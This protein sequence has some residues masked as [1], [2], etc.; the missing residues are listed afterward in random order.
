M[1]PIGSIPPIRHPDPVEPLRQ[2]APAGAAAFSSALAGALEGV[3]ALQKNAESEITRFLSGEAV[4]I[5]QVALAHQ[6]AQLSFELFL[7]VR[8]KFVQ[9]YQEIMRMQI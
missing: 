6:Q 7:Q 9:A 3:D 5:H 8:N 4:D 2:S 1:T